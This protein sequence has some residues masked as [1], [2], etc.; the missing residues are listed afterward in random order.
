MQGISPP[1]DTSKECVDS[2]VFTVS[3]ASANSLSSRV[4]GEKLWTRSRRS[5]SP[6]STRI[7][8]TS[9]MAPEVR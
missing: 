2:T 4:I 5:T 3:I 7:V 1:S 6:I 8:S 9:P